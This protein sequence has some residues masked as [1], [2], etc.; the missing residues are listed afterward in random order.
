LS[1][2][3]RVPQAD[4]WPNDNGYETLTLR[5]AREARDRVL[6]EKALAE[7][8][9]RVQQDTARLRFIASLEDAQLA[10]FKHEAKQRVD[11]RPEAKFLESRYPLYKTEEDTL[12]LEWMDRVAY[13]ETV[14]RLSKSDG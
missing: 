5:Q 1:H 4:I 8:T 9:L 12:T 14:P 11:K 2:Y 3:L 7:E 10:W 6:A 13:G